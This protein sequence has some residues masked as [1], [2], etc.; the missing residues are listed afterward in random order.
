[1]FPTG[2]FMSRNL[3]IHVFKSVCVAFLVEIPNAEHLPV[4]FFYNLA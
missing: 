2:T 3:H 1:M 4:G